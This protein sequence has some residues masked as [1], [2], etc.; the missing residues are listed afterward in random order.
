MGTGCGAV[1]IS[2][3]KEVQ[4]AKI[5]ATDIS[6]GALKVAET[7]A[8]KH[9][10][11]DR[12]SFLQ[13]DL[14]E[15]L[16]D[17]RLT[18]D[19]VLSNPPYVASEE[20]GDLSPEIR[21]YEPR[22]ASIGHEGGMRFIEKIIFEAPPFINPGGWIMVEMAPNQTEK[23]MDLMEKSAAYGEKARI[24]DY[25]HQYRVVMAKRIGLLH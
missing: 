6:A 25:S 7:N 9:G 16:S 18:F 21:N 5:Y 4:S 20:Y 1:A 11:S 24:K 2:V 13:G 22:L 14:W 8:R 23:A 12:I 15:A 10:V 3:A 17:Q 19:I